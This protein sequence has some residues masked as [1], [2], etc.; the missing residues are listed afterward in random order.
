MCAQALQRSHVSLIHTEIKLGP[1]S[2]IQNN[3]GFHIVDP[4]FKRVLP[5]QDNS[6]RDKVN[7]ALGQTSLSHA[8]TLHRYSR[9]S[10][11]CIYIETK[12]KCITNESHTLQNNLGS[13]T[14]CAALLEGFMLHQQHMTA[15]WGGWEYTYTIFVQ[16]TM[17]TRGVI[18]VKY[19]Y[20]AEPA[21]K[22]TSLMMTNKQ[23]WNTPRSGRLG[24]QK[25][26]VNC[27]WK[28][29]P[30]MKNG[31][32]NAD[33]LSTQY[34]SATQKRSKTSTIYRILWECYDIKRAT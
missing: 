20:I 34:P 29:H 13:Y 18:S 31:R 24:A 11:I 23:D 22:Q 8:T 7:T 6:H 27:Q 30:P 2:L 21:H 12:Q 26:Y 10:H 4:T 25:Q 19:L 17:Y 28:H 16:R 14:N 3:H 1:D 15:G 32:K 5:P 33:T 9:Q